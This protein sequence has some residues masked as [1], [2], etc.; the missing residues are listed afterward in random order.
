MTPQ[1]PIIQTPSEY[2]NLY[3]RPPVLSSFTTQ[4]QRV[5]MGYTH[6]NKYELPEVN[7]PWHGIA[8]FTTAGVSERKIDGI[9][10]VVS[11]APGDMIVVPAN[12]S[13][14]TLWQS[15]ANVIVIGLDPALFTETIDDTVQFT[16]P[17]LLPKFP[18]ADPLV[19]QLGLS[20]KS[21]LERD[22]LGS[23]LY[24]ETAAS[25]LA[26]H[27]LQHY[28]HRPLEYKCYPDGLPRSTL[29]KVIDYMQIH[30]DRNLGLTELAKIANLSPHYFTRLFKQ[31]TGLTPH[32][33][34][35]RC[36]VE[37]AKSLLIKGKDSIADIAQQAGFAN[38]AHL[39]MHLKRLLGITPNMILK[40]RTNL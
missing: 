40:Q 1:L 9:T 36:R 2:A 35:I 38:Q 33:F 8:L 5:W 34:V 11:N 27:L 10:Q 26:V 12:V 3:P 30:L 39:N 18:T 19:Y 37:R 21:V 15:A 7:V 14:C 22:P 23:R 32:Q 4:W 25:M 20:L 16:Q 13:H 6:Q 29:S 28:S 24:A 17:K 31:S